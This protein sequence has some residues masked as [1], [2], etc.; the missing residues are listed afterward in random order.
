MPFKMAMKLKSGLIEEKLI[1]ADFPNSNPTKNLWKAFLFE[2]FRIKQALPK[3]SKKNQS[4]LLQ[5]N[6]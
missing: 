5:G 4:P 3:H 2:I 1:K 6:F